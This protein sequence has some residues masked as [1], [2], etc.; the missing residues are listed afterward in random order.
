M[1]TLNFPHLLAS[2]VLFWAIISGTST[3]LAEATAP[4]KL[5]PTDRV[6]IFVTVP[7]QAFLV[8][9]IGGDA[10][11][12]HTLV[13]KGQDPHTFEPT[14]RQ[15]ASLARANLFFTVDI[16]FE[17][18]LVAKVAASNRKLQI[19]DSSR[20][21]I[22]LPLTEPHH[23][24]THAKK[25]HSS[26]EADP[27]V[28]LATD[29]LRIMAVNMTAALS[30]I[31]PEHKEILDRNLA[32]LQSEINAVGKC[33]TTTLTPHRGKT[34]Y[35]FH[36]AFGYFAHAYGLKQRAV[37]ISGKSP[38][39]RQLTALVNQA[40]KDRAQTIFVQP[41]FDRKSAET[42]AQAINGTVV[43]IDPLDREVLRNLV[44]IAAAIDQS[45]KERRKSP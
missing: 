34:F 30:A 36:P 12:V 28:W 4:L 25:E 31:L 13:G 5:Q 21:I 41:Q 37:E 22:R 18:Q 19:V 44:T 15:A 8:E 35:I 9:R 29:N 23:H 39:P 24:E 3:D 6:R 20:G 32:S 7:P 43:P 17:R 16:P 27:H 2:A 45:L 11:E 38:T 42:V 26:N 1:P 33:L 40:K 10:V 14:P